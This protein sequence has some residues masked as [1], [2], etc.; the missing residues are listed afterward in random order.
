MEGHGFLHFARTVSACTFLSRIL[1]LVRDVLCAS[2]FGAGGVWD[3]FVVA[4]RV[5]NLFRRM[6]GEG[7]LSLAFIPVMAEYTENRSE[8]ETRELVSVVFTAAGG[9]LAILVMLGVGGAWGYYRVVKPSGN[10][11]LLVRLL[12]LTIPYAV[13]ICLTAVSMAVLNT[14]RHFVMPALA[15]A[16]LNIFWIGGVVLLVPFIGIYGVAA[17]VLA[18]GVAQLGMQL[19][20]LARKGL[21][22]RVRLNLKHPGLVRTAKL[23]LPVLVGSA[24][25]QINILL[26]SVIAWLF[27]G[28]GGVASLYYGDR[29]VQFPLGVFGLAVTTA[30]FPAFA[31]RAAAGDMEGLADSVSQALRAIVFIALPAALGLVLMRTEVVELIFKRGSFTDEAAVRTSRV[32]LFYSLGL[33]SYCGVHVLTRAFYSIGD[34]RT[35]VRLSLLTIGCNVALNLSLVWVLKEAGI[36]LATALTATLGFSLLF[37]KLRRRLSE[38]NGREVMGAVGRAAFGC[39]FLAAAVIGVMELVGEGDSLLM[40]FV[41]VVLPVMAGVLAYGGASVVMGTREM[42]EIMAR[43]G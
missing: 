7:S 26:D 11:A 27:A 13:F 36:A 43:R 3:A 19:P 18:G 25:M 37:W 20:V 10:A 9:L 16:V 42:K 23:M 17:A 6:F 4:F 1:G 29:L 5:P 34:M 38:I 41:G 30:A 35:P 21:M 2:V 28:E 40:R 14:R 31:R 39:V 12:W 32:L 22:P 24:A 33:F 15:P 8:A